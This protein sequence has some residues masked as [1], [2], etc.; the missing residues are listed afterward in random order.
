MDFQW[1]INWKIKIY[2]KLISFK[3]FAEQY[4]GKVNQNEKKIM[5]LKMKIMLHNITLFVNFPKRLNFQFQSVE[6]FLISFIFISISRRKFWQ[7]PNKILYP[8][9]IHLNMNYVQVKW[10]ADDHNIIQFIN[11]PKNPRKT[12]NSL[13]INATTFRNTNTLNYLWKLIQI[14][15]MK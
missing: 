2:L 10:S 15:K 3:L 6:K 7:I 14:S 4:F 1:T 12:E 9:Q 5:V 13:I 11:R 8:N